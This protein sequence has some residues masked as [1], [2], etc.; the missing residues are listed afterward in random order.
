M[1]AFTANRP[2]I[3]LGHVIAICREAVKLAQMAYQTTAIRLGAVLNLAITLGVAPLGAEETQHSGVVSPAQQFEMIRS[4]EGRWQVAET[5]AL[6]IVFEPT[7]RG[8]AMIERWETKSGL[9]SVTIYHMDGGVLVATHYCPQGNQPRLEAR[10][11]PVGPVRFTFRD[12][13]G[14]DEG[15]SHAH[16]LAFAAADDGS[17]VRSEVY[18]G[19]EGLQEPSHYTLSRKA[20]DQ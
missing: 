11:G 14:L 3:Q 18:R 2:R 12:V 20:L 6:E 9:H 13:T 19:S 5:S 4:W 15:E 1:R 16:D 17:I 8:S 10:S 7:A